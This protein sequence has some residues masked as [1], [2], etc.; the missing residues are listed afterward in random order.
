MAASKKSYSA[1]EALQFILNSDN[2]S[3]DQSSDET[4]DGESEEDFSPNLQDE[5]LSE[6]SSLLLLLATDFC[7][8][9]VDIYHLF[10]FL[11]W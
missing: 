7:Q 3:S 10:P 8:G 9:R 2:E 4:T 5:S 11:N 1:S 6:V